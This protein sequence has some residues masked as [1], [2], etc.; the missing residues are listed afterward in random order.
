MFG[1]ELAQ[2]TQAVLALLILV[3]MLVMF[4]RETYPVEVVAIGADRKSVV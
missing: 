4:L 2:S 1:F 3:G